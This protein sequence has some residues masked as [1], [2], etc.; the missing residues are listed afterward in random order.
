MR[1]IGA[2]DIR[3]KRRLDKILMARMVEQPF[4]EEMLFGGIEADELDRRPIAKA[5]EQA[6][7]DR[8]TAGGLLAG[9]SLAQVEIVFDLAA[10]VIL[11]ALVGI[12]VADRRIDA[13]AIDDVSIRLEERE[14]PVV[15]FVSAAA[16]RDETEQR[17]RVDI[18]PSRQHEADV[19]GIERGPE[20]IADLLLMTVLAVLPH[21]NAKVAD[22]GERQCRRLV[23]RRHVGAKPVVISASLDERL[24]GGRPVP[25]LA[26]GPFLAFD[27]DLVG[28]LR[29][30]LEA[31]DPAVIRG[32]GGGDGHR[33]AA[34]VRHFHRRGSVRGRSRTNRVSPRGVNVFQI[35]VVHEL[36]FAARRRLEIERTPGDQR[37]L[38]ADRWQV[39]VGLGM[40]LRHVVTSE[41]HRLEN[42]SS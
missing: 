8:R 39:D 16:A 27:D 5:V 7:P 35:V 26:L 2:G 38:V 15:V 28:V 22:D 3:A 33:S 25:P 30:R 34:R 31:R 13:D 6:G 23:E 36:H 41:V 29:V 9:Y 12:V 17:L 37:R 1:Q 11:L 4:G 42:P 18:V 24:P 10:I 19:V 32:V 21:A 14:E 40:K 20:R